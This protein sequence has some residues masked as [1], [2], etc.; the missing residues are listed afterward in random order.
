M[1]QQGSTRRGDARRVAG[2]RGSV[3]HPRQRE[4]PSAMPRRR[5]VAGGGSAPFPRSAGS[6]AA[7]SGPPDRRRAPDQ[8]PVVR[9]IQQ[10]PAG[11]VAVHARVFVSFFTTIMSTA[12][13]DERQ[14]SAA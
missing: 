14:V 3:E 13:R 4:S 11:H 10:A 9:V 12:A 8:P 5:C 1:P 6:I 2:I 7:T